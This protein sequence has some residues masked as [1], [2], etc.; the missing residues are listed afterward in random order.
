MPSYAVIPQRVGTEVAAADLTGKAKLGVKLA[1]NGWNIAGAGEGGVG[2]LYY[3][4][5]EG[6]ACSVGIGGGEEAIAGAAIAKGASVEVGTG[7]K[8]ITLASGTKVGTA[9]TAA[10]GADAEF[11]LLINF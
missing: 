8:F 11:T 7:G 4:A 10:S 6:E 9:L 2:V 5:K 1:A 3:E